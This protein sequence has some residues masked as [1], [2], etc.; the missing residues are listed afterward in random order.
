MSQIANNHNKEMAQYGYFK[1]PSPINQPGDTYA[2]YARLKVNPAVAGHETCISEVLYWANWL[3]GPRPPSLGSPGAAIFWAMYQDSHS[4][5]GHREA[6]LGRSCTFNGNQ[7]FGQ[8]DW[9]GIGIVSVQDKSDGSGRI[10]YT[11]DFLGDAKA[12]T[13]TPPATADT[14]PPTMDAPTI[15]DANTVQV[16]N[17]TDDS[18]GSTSAVAGVTGVV[19]YIGS[20]VQNGNFQTVVAKQDPPGTWTA[21]LSATDPTTLHAVAVDGSGNDT[22]TAGNPSS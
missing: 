21:T 10:Y 19:F 18:D 1:H 8:F 12:T 7:P 14:Q 6:I 4:Q 20:A 9:I 17:V 2:P 11:L 22:D 3:G 5:W 16:I 13:Y 15:V